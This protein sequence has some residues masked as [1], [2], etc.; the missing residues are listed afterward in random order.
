MAAIRPLRRPRGARRRLRSP[1]PEVR[2]RLLKAA[3]DL[4]EEGGVPQLRVEEI[5]QRA[6]LSVGTV[7][8]YFDGKDDLFA[9]L[10]VE[11]TQRLRDALSSTYRSDR[12]LLERFSRSLDTYLDFVSGHR[13]G[14]LYFRDSSTVH[15][16]VG[17]LST[18]AMN[19]FADAMLPMCEEAVAAGY[20]RREDPR[21]LAQALVG[22]IHHMAGYWLEH[23]DAVSRGDVQRFLGRLVVRGL[24]S[25]EVS[26]AT[27]APGVHAS[28]GAQAPQPVAEAAPEAESNDLEEE[29][30]HGDRLAGDRG[31]D[32]NAERERDN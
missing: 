7:Y 28:G 15:T 4:I 3:S 32:T 27:P 30:A 18:W 1:N 8:L 14:F 31:T 16:T 26:A 9:N 21:L 22:L 24:V 5:A 19:Q 10:I 25:A 2:R 11:H 20:L 29:P 17:P 13:R 6:G 12:P 23:Q